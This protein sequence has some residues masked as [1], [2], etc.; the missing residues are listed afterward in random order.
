MFNLEYTSLYI[1]ILVDILSNCGLE[2][3]SCLVNQEFRYQF[4]IRILYLYGKDDILYG[5]YLENRA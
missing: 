1:L 5:L 4:Q 3:N 2:D